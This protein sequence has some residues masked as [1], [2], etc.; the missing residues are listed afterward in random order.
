MWMFS[1]ALDT[2]SSLSRSSRVQWLAWVGKPASKKCLCSV[3]ALLLLYLPW[4][5][6]PVCTGQ[7][8][9]QLRSL[10]SSSLRAHLGGDGLSQR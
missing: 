3:R 6:C 7:V 8:W 2:R 4:S 1:G 9:V 10:H 5:V